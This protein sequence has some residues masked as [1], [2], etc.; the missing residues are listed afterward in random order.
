MAVKGQLAERGLKGSLD[1]EG[2]KFLGIYYD[3]QDDHLLL[4]QDVNTLQLIK[5]LRMDD[6]KRMSTPMEPGFERDRDQEEEK[7]DQQPTDTPFYQSIVGQAIWLL[8]TRYD[9]AF[10]I[11]QLA[12]DMATPTQASLKRAKRL[13]R[14]LIGSPRRG[15]IF[16]RGLPGEHL[17]TYCYVESLPLSKKNQSLV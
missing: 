4:H 13:V 12:L 15:L 14:Y 7:A 3:N 1:E 9:C 17:Q 8:R 16:N 6:A 5:S 10:T 11:Q 2:K